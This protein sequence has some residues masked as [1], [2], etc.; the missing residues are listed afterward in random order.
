MANPSPGNL[1]SLRVAAPSSFNDDAHAN[2]VGVALSALDG[3]TV[4]HVS[5]RAFLMHLGGKLEVVSNV[6]LRNRDNLSRAYTPGV[7]RACF[8]IA[9]GPVSGP[10]PDPKAQHHRRPYQRF[11]RSGLGQTLAR[12]RPARCGSQGRPFQAVRQC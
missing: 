11:D 8:A 5:D 6:A 10:Q 3:V 7:A 2:R 1:V 4:Q 12:P 9:E